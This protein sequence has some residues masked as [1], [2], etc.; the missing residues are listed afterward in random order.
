MKV[1]D[2]NNIVYNVMFEVTNCRQELFE[3]IALFSMK[4]LYNEPFSRSLISQTLVS[5]KVRDIV[6]RYKTKLRK[7]T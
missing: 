1:V 4:F 7:S 6:G 2:L 3:K 5:Y